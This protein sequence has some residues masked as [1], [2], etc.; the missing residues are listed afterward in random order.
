[1]AQQGKSQWGKVLW[2]GTSVALLIIAILVGY[3]YGITLWNWLKLLIVPAVIAGGGIWFNRQQRERELGIAERRAQDEAL[4]AYLDKMTELL[5]VHKLG[6]PDEGPN[7]RTVAWAR[8]KT[9]LRRLDTSNQGAVH[10][11]AVLRFLNDAELI[12]TSRPII[13]SLSGAHLQGANLERSYL[14]DVALRGVDLSGATLRGANLGGANLGRSEDTERPTDLSGAD[15]SGAD[16]SGATLTEQQLAQAESLE[17]ATMPNGQKY[18]DWLN[19]KE[20]RTEDAE[21]D[22]P[23]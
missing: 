1:V 22:G 18:E 15:L 3:R 12:S 5:V 11:G 19:D 2:I 13:R 16:L 23:Q 10:K 9:V 6:K 20:G 17:E 7:V 14:V 4:Q 21:N 8:I